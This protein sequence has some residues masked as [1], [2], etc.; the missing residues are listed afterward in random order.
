VLELSIY[1]EPFECQHSDILRTILADETSFAG[2]PLVDFAK[3]YFAVKGKKKEVEADAISSLI[4]KLTTVKLYKRG[5][6]VDFK[7]LWR[8]IVLE[9]YPL[10]AYNFNSY[11][12]NN[13]SG[14]SY[15]K[16]VVQYIRLM[17]AQKKETES[18][19]EAI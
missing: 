12:G 19:A 1:L 13:I 4:S 7:S 17:D 11:Y 2:S 5:D 14:V 8:K 9:R 18:Q 3:S 10:L 15:E 16:S 6:V